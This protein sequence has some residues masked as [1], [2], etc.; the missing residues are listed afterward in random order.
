MK[1]SLP[2]QWLTYSQQMT[3]DGSTLLLT[4]GCRVIW[5][6]VCFSSVN[7]KGPSFS[8]LLL[9]IAGN[10]GS[11]LNADLMVFVCLF[12]KCRAFPSCL[13]CHLYFILASSF[14][15]FPQPLLHLVCRPS[16]SVSSHLS[17]ALHFPGR[18]LNSV[19]SSLTSRTH[20]LESHSHSPRLCL[21]ASAN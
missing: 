2:P 12:V 9:T 19:T 8:W 15:V 18:S 20:L 10:N 5:R 7:F 17:S 4:L 13:F 11:A 6:A 14:L 21:L 1:D 16:A 3:W